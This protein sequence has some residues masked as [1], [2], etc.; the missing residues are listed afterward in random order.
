MHGQE[1]MESYR[2]DLRTPS[3]DEFEALGR[4][5]MN[6]LPEEFRNLC[7]DVQIVAADA[8]SAD[9]LDEL[10]VEDPLD[11]LG[12]FEGIGMA[13]GATEIRTGQMPN[14]I[15]LYRNAILDYWRD[16]DET[17][18]AI[19]LHVL[20]HEIGH[21]FGFSDDDMEAIEDELD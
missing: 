14:R 8:A 18:E 15:W 2:S 13:Q 5:A 4:A 1:L 6:S 17:L 7:K 20:V 11:L 19:V 9:V 10:G 3:L 21:H 16:H 12:L